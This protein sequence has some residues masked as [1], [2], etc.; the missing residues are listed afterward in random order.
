MINCHTIKAYALANGWSQIKS[1]LAEGEEF[2]KDKFLFS[3][4][5]VDDLEL[6]ADVLSYAI[7]QTANQEGISPVEVAN[8]IANQWLPFDPDNIP[9]AKEGWCLLVKD[10]ED[11][12]IHAF[13]VHNGSWRIHPMGTSFQE[14]IAKYGADKYQNKTYKLI[15]L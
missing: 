7:T 5:T 10:L 2:V 11:Y 12:T 6:E 8:K 4:P 9:E 3:L 14:L 15:Q 1:N 13:K